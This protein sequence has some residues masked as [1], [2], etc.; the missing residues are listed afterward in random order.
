MRR[1]G[2]RSR[3]G[4]YWTL[5]IAL[6]GGCLGWALFLRG[7]KDPI[8]IISRDGDVRITESVLTTG[9]N[10]LYYF[11][12]GLD[13][14]WDP[15]GNRLSDS[16]V[17]RMRYVTSG[18]TAVL[19]LRFIHPDYAIAPPLPTGSL[20]LAPFR[21]E[22]IDTNGGRTD[23]MQID[24]QVQNY[25]GGYIVLGWELPRHLSDLRHGTLKLEATN[26]TGS[27]VLRL[28]AR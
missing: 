26:G 28:T 8:E 17:N 1:D 27:A 24:A 11:G 12:E 25:L 6:V 16:D 3:Y 19:W 13:R 22:W 2:R 20:A 9:F 18:N 7:S 21:A 10:H 15:I 14:L 5:A 4:L 23:L